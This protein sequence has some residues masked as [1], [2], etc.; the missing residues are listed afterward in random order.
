M[1]EEKLNE[2]IICPLCGSATTEKSCP[3]CGEDLGLL[4][5]IRRRA[6][7]CYNLGL[8]L[9]KRNKSE[10]EECLKM[11]IE[12]DAGL[13]GSYIV[14]G[15]ICALQRRYSEAIENWQKALTLNRD[16]KEAL[17]CLQGFQALFESTAT[18]RL[19]STWQGKPLR[20]GSEVRDPA[21]HRARIW[22][23]LPNDENE[24]LTY[25]VIWKNSFTPEDAMVPVEYI[26]GIDGY[27]V[28]V[29]ETL[30][31]LF[32]SIPKYRPYSTQGR[33]NS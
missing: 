11:A 33:K 18:L 6:I 7:R 17:D 23:L 22:R 31:K 19:E 12:L 16:N 1:N 5:D 8:R 15:K 25:I 20:I 4:H 13:S 26:T 14:L 3:D 30:R 24:D 29:K 27:T 32:S 21:G 2:T 10:A 9:V 28:F